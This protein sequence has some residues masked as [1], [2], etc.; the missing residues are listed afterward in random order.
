MRHLVKKY[1]IPHQGNDYRP[2]FFR[3][4]SVL[5][6]VALVVVIF[7]STLGY[8]LVI[9][10]IATLAA[11]LPSVL[12]DL[13]NDNRSIYNISA[14][15]Y[16]PVLA[17]SAQEKAQD[18]A[19]Y[20]YFA[21]ES[22]TGITPWYWFTK[23]GYRFIYAG[24]NLAVNFSDSR[25]VSSAWMNSASHRANVLNLNF[26]EIGIGVAEGMYQGRPT[27]FVVEHFGRP[28]LPSQKVTEDL[29]VTPVVVTDIR[30]DNTLVA[31]A[32]KELV[33]LD[34]RVAV[35]EA[36]K[37]ETLG[38]T[39]YASRAK[40]VVSSPGIILNIAYLILGILIIGLSLVSVFIETRRHHAK[41]VLS[42]VGMLVVMLALLWAYHIFAS[43]M[44]IVV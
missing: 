25:E 38:A 27:L 14:L 6:V 4:R 8:G 12:I 37:V 36:D 32:N 42:A 39:N 34:E 1:V 15:K 18:M 20:S 2:H 44:L 31:V 5:G 23:N 33:E 3:A 26:T 17:A 9:P 19:R 24:E 29:P 35:E 41:H 13:T 10:R 30:G 43:R 7:V 16:N 11:I 22:P 21:H 40:E 28:Y